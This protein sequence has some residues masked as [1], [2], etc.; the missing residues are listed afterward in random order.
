MFLAA[1]TKSE[2][3]KNKKILKKKSQNG[4]RSHEMGTG[5]RGEEKALEM[6]GVVHREWGDN[7]QNVSCTSTRLSKNK[8]NKGFQNHGSTLYSR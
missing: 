7:N 3:K 4:A 1:Q 2:I 6:L 5:H 8:F